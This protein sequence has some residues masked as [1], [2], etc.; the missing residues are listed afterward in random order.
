MKNIL[1]V[2]LLITSVLSC[3][4]NI[5]EQQTNIHELTGTWER[6]DSNTTLQNTIVFNEDFTGIKTSFKKDGDFMISN[7]SDFE[8]IASESQLT[9]NLYEEIQ[10]SYFFNEEGQLVLSALSTIPYNKID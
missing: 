9:I 4:N 6:S 8:W 10:T 7:A 3:T 2:F 5:S 1:F